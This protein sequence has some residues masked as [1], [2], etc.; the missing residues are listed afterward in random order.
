M[1]RIQG[2]VLGAAL[3]FG[4][5]AVPATVGAQAAR[6]AGVRTSAFNVPSA[7]QSSAHKPC[8]PQRRQKSVQSAGTSAGAVCDP[9]P[10]RVNLTWPTGLGTLSVQTSSD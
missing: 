6:S 10:I 8:R 9:K 4:A 5:L 7:R 2:T 1:H 3:L